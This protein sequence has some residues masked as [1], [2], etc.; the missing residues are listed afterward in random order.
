MSETAEHAGEATLLV[1]FS[2]L[3]LRA[4]EDDADVRL[5]RAVAA[6]A[7]LRPRPQAVL[8]TGDLAD[9]P[10]AELYERAHRALAA[11]GRPVHAIPGNHDDRDL[12]A[13]TFAA[14]EQASGA[15]VHVLAYV[16]DLR[17]VG[18]DTTVP[19]Q[20][21]GALDPEQLRWLD[22]TLSDEPARPTLLALHHPPVGTGVRAM[23]AIGLDP[24]DAESLASLLGGH[25]QVTAVT[26]G[27]VHRTV[28]TEFAGRP[29][30]VCPSTNSTLRL[31]LRPE[32]GLPL[33]FD[34]QPLGFA[35]HLLAGGRLTSHV[36]AL[37]AGC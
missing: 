11:L 18:C 13:A 29:L 9:E 17:L 34:E 2:D 32:E 7:A 35:V 20:P 14:R 15:P 24:A 19:G 27:H 4:R 3:H 28:T 30:L 1:Q 6:A 22:R 16:G 12:L 5:A 10:T 21:G 33:A 31:D 25:P 37:E 26:C 36:Q 8:V 23:D